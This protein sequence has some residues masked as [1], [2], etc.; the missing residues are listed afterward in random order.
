MS[1]KFHSFIKRQYCDD[2]RLHWGSGL[3]APETVSHIQ[4][5]MSKAQRTLAS[6]IFMKTNSGNFLNYLVEANQLGLSSRNPTICSLSNFPCQKSDLQHRTLCG[7]VKPICPV[8]KFSCR[9][10]K[11][12]LSTKSCRKTCQTSE[13][14]CGSSGCSNSSTIISMPSVPTD[15]KKIFVMFCHMSMLQK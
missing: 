7:I 5:C 6:T 11:F 9:L 4:H 1:R 15:G 10:C 14:F 13:K 2:V 12:Y 8:L 3:S